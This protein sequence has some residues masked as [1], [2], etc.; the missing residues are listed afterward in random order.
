MA[1]LESEMFG[2]ERGGFTGAIAQRIGRF[3]L[4]HRGTMFLDKVGEIPLELQTKLL[5]VLAGAGIRAV[6]QFAHDPHRRAAGGGDKIEI[7]RRWW[8]R[9][10]SALICTTASMCPR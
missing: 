7:W 3:E 8:K 4:T 6:K 10:N 9:A 2:H 5:R 1:S